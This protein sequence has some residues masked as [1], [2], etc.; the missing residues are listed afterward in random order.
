MK[1]NIV[2]LLLCGALLLSGCGLLR[3]EYSRME[4]H[5]ATYYEGDRRDVLRAESYQDL[6]NDLLLL[7]A[8]H[9]EEGTVWYYA[10]EETDLSREAQ[11]A[12]AEVQQETPLGAYALDYL[13]Y[14]VDDGG[15]GYTQLRFTAGYRRTLQQIQSIV[16]ATGGA[17]LTDLL[18]AAAQNGGKELVVQMGTSGSTRQAVLVEGMEGEFSVGHA[19]NYVKVYIPGQCP[20]NEIQTVTVTALHQDGVTAERN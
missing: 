18:R 14:T 4:P 9:A 11:R 13:T 6:V 8:A 7:V 2:F 5:S 20:R 3:R 16:H 15:R 1:K 10:E 19:P 17:A 12:C